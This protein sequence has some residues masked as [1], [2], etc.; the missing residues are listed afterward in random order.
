ML[1]LKI[2]LRYLMPFKVI[3][4]YLEPRY[5]ILDFPFPALTLYAS[6]FMVYCTQRSYASYN[7]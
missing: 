1:Y 4:Y 3:I 2:T 7:S 5:C 6:R